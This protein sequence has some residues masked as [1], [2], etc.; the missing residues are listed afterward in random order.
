VGPYASDFHRPLSDYINHVLALDCNLIELVEPR[1]DADAVAN[2]PDG[3]QAYAHLPN[4]I[5][6]AARRA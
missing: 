1:L 3:V 4:F 2:G 6:V 5:V